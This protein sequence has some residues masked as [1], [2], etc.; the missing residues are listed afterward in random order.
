M[1]KTDHRGRSFLERIIDIC[2]SLPLEVIPCQ[3]GE[4][5]PP[6]TDEVLPEAKQLR[7]LQKHTETALGVSAIERMRELISKLE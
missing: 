5:S 2:A 4:M 3:V 1:K 7:A 6:V